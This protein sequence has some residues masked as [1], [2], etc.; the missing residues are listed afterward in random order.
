[1]VTLAGG[2][3]SFVGVLLLLG[4]VLVPA[5]L[6][7]LG[8]VASWG[9]GV[10]GRVAVLNARRNARRTA[11]SA[12]SLLV[13][14]TLIT[15]V[16]VGMTTI[17]TLTSGEMD[18]QYPLDAAIT[19]GSP[20]APD[21]LQ[22]VRDLD[23]VDRAAEVSGLAATVTAGEVRLRDVVLLAPSAEAADVAHGRPGFLD[24]GDGE[25]YLPW[26][27]INEEGLS[28]DKSV[29]VT[30]RG[31]ERSLRLRG[32]DGFGAAAIVAPA[33]L[34]ALGGDDVAPRAVWDAADQSADAADTFGALET[35]ASTEGAEI[36]G[37][38]LNRDWVELQ[39]DVITGAAVSLLGIAVVIALVGIASSLGLSVLERTREHALLRA[40]GLTRRQMRATLAIEAGILATL[41]AALGIA[42]GSAY[43]WVAVRTVAGRVLGE[44]TLDLPAGQLTIVVL[45]ALLAG[46]AACV[47]PAR[48][49]ARIAPAAGLAAD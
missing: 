38:L 33:T 19:S 24:A 29:T 27:T 2:F 48:R 45:A 35:V 1:V 49:A 23:G 12:A 7:L 26:D 31:Q 22:R 41:A 42:L 6:R 14:V 25:L 43:A 21:A 32:S 5:L 28:P 17:R 34:T 11:A 10:P 44:V 13:G 15:G 37:G 16:L 18:E 4:P 46:L 40:M 39:L 8:P 47:L 36:D 20:L 3:V 9:L 30:V